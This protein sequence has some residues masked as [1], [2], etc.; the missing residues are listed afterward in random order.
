MTALAR[1]AGIGPSSAHRILTALCRKGLVE[2]ERGSDRYELAWGVL[3]LGRALGGRADLRA[4]SLPELEALRDL[5]GETLTL[6]VRSGNERIC[7]ECLESPHE[8]RWIAAVGART[9]LHAGASGRVLL[10]QLAPEELDRYLA[11][12]AAD[13]PAQLPAA[14]AAATLRRTVAA[15]RK[16]GYELAAD[17]RVLGIGGIAAPIGVTACLTIAGPT[18]RCTPERLAGWLGALRDS[19]D[20]INR[21]LE[22]ARS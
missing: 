15:V 16:R 5:T 7:A 6:W 21:H 20:R 3:R 22:G 2:Q 14:A 9:P 11:E 10:S 12:I 13:K 1:E 4:L 8:L 19:T 17:D 18:A